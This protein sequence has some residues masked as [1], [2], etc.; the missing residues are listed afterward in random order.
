MKTHASNTRSREQEH[1][2][3]VRHFIPPISMTVCQVKGSTPKL[4]QTN[5]FVFWL[6]P[7]RDRPPS[8]FSW[9]SQKKVTSKQVK[10][11]ELSLRWYLSPYSDALTQV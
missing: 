9:F 7:G 1:Q 5:W 3:V 10:R 6:F 2:A 8:G 4:K 11:V